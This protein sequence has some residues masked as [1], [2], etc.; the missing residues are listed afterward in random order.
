MC[1][2]G[3]GRRLRESLFKDVG[4]DCAVR[5]GVSGVDNFT[6]HS[7]CSLVWYVESEKSQRTTI[8]IYM[9]IDEVKGKSH[10]PFGAEDP[11]LS[12]HFDIAHHRNGNQKICRSPA[13]MFTYVH[14]G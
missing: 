6:I 3:R 12:R 2:E 14:R 7:L 11:K 10:L 13:P 9:Y 4:D 1:G 5:N 8:I